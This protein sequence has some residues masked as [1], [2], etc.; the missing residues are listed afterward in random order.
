[1]TVIGYDTAG[2]I[3]A[4]AITFMGPIASFHLC[5][6]DSSQEP[7][8]GDRSKAELHREKN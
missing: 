1:M 8:E 4:W 6:F 2:P 5:H 7:A 3:P